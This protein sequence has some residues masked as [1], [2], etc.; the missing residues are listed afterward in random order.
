M[1]LYLTQEN[2]LV[3]IAIAVVF[4]LGWLAHR[5]LTVR[6]ENASIDELTHQIERLQRQRDAAHKVSLELAATHNKLVGEHLEAEW[7]IHS[8][9]SDLAVRDERIKKLLVAANADL[10][11]IKTEVWSVE[12]ARFR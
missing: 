5:W 2:I 9:K 8:L 12:E 1:D 3:A 11:P 6:R 7:T 4:A 10:H